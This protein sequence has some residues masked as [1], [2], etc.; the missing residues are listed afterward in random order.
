MSLFS[1]D[2][3]TTVPDTFRKKSLKYG[4]YNKDYIVG[5]RLVTHEGFKNNFHVILDNV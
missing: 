1:I 5:S 4:L 2:E 3:N